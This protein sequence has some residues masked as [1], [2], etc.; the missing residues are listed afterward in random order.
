MTSDAKIQFL[1]FPSDALLP[2]KASVVCFFGPGCS[3]PIVIFLLFLILKVWRRPEQAINIYFFPLPKVS[4]RKIKCSFFL[5][6]MCWC[7]ALM[8]GWVAV[9]LGWWL[10]CVGVL[11]CSSTHRHI[12]TSTHQQIRTSAHQ[13]INTSIHQHTS[14]HQH[15][16]TSTQ[17]IHTS[18]HQHINISTQHNVTASAQLLDVFF[19]SLLKYPFPVFSVFIWFLDAQRIF[20]KFSVD[21]PR[22]SVSRVFSWCQLSL[23]PYKH[24]VATRLSR[25]FRM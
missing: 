9:L 18:T 20:S 12:N 3:I 1:S 16:N 22:K 14:T 23:Q 25:E 11:M 13:H 6:E 10:W 4:P 24:T 5:V 7:R 2:Q 15:V 17:H 8:C 19:F 21:I